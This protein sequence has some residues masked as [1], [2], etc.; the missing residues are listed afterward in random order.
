M[1]YPARPRQSARIVTTNVEESAE[2]EV[3]DR[4]TVKAKG[5]IV[6][7]LTRQ[8]VYLENCSSQMSEEE[9]SFQ[10][11][12][13][14]PDNREEVTMSNMR[15]PQGTRQARNRRMPNGTYGGVGGRK[16]KVGQKT[17]YVF[18]PTRFDFQEF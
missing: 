1:A 13:A 16:T 3:A 4:V 7:C 15:S 2:A 10:D 5:R 8:S 12:R 11:D 18:R 9:L 17:Y 14:Y 6:H